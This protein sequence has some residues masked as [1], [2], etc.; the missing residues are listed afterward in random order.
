[1]VNCYKL[2]TSTYFFMLRPSHFT[3]YCKEPVISSIILTYRNL[4]V[5]FELLWLTF[6]LQY[7]YGLQIQ[8]SSSLP[9]YQGSKYVFV[10]A[11]L[12]D[13]SVHLCCFNT[14]TFSFLLDYHT[15]YILDIYN[16]HVKASLVH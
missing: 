4:V 10:L 7:R 9:K 14:D 11:S 5:L 2:Y 8:F 1:M 3:L 12:K 13:L 6:I 15:I 16:T